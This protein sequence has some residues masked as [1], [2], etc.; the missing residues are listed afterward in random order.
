M[1]RIWRF[2]GHMPILVRLLLLGTQGFLLL[3]WGLAGKHVYMFTMI[4]CK[5]STILTQVAVTAFC[6]TE[7]FTNA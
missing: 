6:S 4:G 1:F 3:A 7:T 5:M 2:H